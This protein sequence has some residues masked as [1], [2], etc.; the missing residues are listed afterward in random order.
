MAASDSH[1]D[2]QIVPLYAHNTVED[3][4]LAI[5]AWERGPRRGYQFEDGKLRVFRKGYYNMLHE[6]DT[7]ADRAIRVVT[8]L[9]RK[10]GHLGEGFEQASNFVAPT[11]EVTFDEQVRI[12]LIERPEGFADA[13]WVADVR[14]IDRPRALKRH[15]VP[16]MTAAKARLSEEAI[17]LALSQDNASEI[18]AAA[19]E[20]L[21]STNLVTASQLAPLSGLPASRHLAFANALR[22]LLYGDDALELRFERYVATLALVHKAGPSWP[23]ATALL[24]LVFPEDHV[25]IR[26]TTL[27]EQAKF[28][29]PRLMFAKTPN[30][31]LYVRYLDMVNAVREK[32]VA[33]GQAPADLM[34]VYDFMV[35][36]LKPSARKLLAH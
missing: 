6:V 4:G 14:G 16:V 12:F 34:D 10:M 5:L 25:C 28:M 21:Q 20:L 8:E 27:R 3:W 31:A 30:A 11:P 24:A 7:P 26:P 15:R 22:A 32:L 36:T 19:V 18:H 17:D 9:K 1:L 29:A 13:K 33:A 35:L 23:L 2:T